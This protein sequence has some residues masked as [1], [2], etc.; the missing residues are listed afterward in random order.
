MGLYLSFSK[1]KKVYF[2]R[3][4]FIRIFFCLNYPPQ[5]PVHS[6]QLQQKLLISN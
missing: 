3:V 4:Y 2:F 5:K 6:Q 1:K